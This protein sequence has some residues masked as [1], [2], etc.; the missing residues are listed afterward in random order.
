V[1]KTGRQTHAAPKSGVWKEKL[2]FEITELGLLTE[3]LN[4]I[5]RG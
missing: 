5:A 3:E 2:S 4:T 1:D